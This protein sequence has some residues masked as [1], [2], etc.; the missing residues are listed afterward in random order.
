[1]YLEF[2][3]LSDFPFRLSPDPKYLYKTESLLEVLANLQYGIESGKGLVVMTGEVG[4]GK[5]TTLRVHLRSLDQRVLAAYI[6]NPLLSTNEF[7]EAL[8]GEFRL[9][10]Q[11][12]KAAMLRMLGNMLLSRHSRGLKTV[13]VV[14]EAHLLPPHLLEEIRLLSNFETNQEKLLQIIL[15][16][17]PELIDLL[18]QPELRQLKQR[19]SLRCSIQP[20]TL[21]DTDEYIKYRLQ[22]AGASNDS[23]FNPEAVSAIHMFS[24]G[25]PRIINNICDNALLAGYSEGKS[26][27]DDEIVK[28]VVSQLGLGGLETGFASASS[29]ALPAF[30]GAGD[31]LDSD[32]PLGPLGFGPVLVSHE[33]A[34]MPRQ[35]VSYIRPEYANYDRGHDSYR[36]S[37]DAVRFIIEFEDGEGSSAASK[38]FSRVKVTKR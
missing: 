30:S 3:G 24:G 25:I 9:R 15:C 11:A 23:I 27:V 37:R 21:E 16:G 10:P 17:Q 38:Y 34:G 26:T 12:S 36:S 1:M 7:F 33:D 19:V 31:L 2:Y 28:D 8:A 13:L 29:S 14:D 20:M 4:T 22:I 6:F 32:E 35:N 5:T 18:D